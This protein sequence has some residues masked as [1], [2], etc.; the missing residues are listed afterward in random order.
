ML[1]GSEKITV[2]VDYFTA[3]IIEF[4]NLFLILWFTH[5]LPFSLFVKNI[6]S[7]YTGIYFY[8]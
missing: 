4:S 3:F 5:E 6:P 1:V 8:H 7:L 2:E